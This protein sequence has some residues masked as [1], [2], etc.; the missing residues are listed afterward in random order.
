MSL[1]RIGG[2]I[3][4]AKRLHTVRR[5]SGRHNVSDRVFLILE[6]RLAA[7]T[8]ATNISRSGRR[9]FNICAPLDHLSADGKARTTKRELSKFA[10]SE[11]VDMKRE[12][13]ARFLP[14]FMRA[15]P[16]IEVLVH[17]VYRINGAV[18]RKRALIVLFSIVDS[19]F[20]S[21]KYIAARGEKGER[22]SHKNRVWLSACERRSL[23]T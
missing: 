14:R 21:D 8:G 17:R 6:H 4:A 15:A 19:L 13:G 12:T 7:S 5:Q 20:L 18:E 16:L 2:T 1:A 9:T 22:E 3:V 11:I 23:H 10:A